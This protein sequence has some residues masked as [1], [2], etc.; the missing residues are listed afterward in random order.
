PKVLPK[1]ATTIAGQ[2]MAGFNCTRAN[3]TGSDP[4]G[5]SVADTKATT[6][7]VLSPTFGNASTASR[8]SIHASIDCIMR[9]PRRSRM[10]RSEPLYFCLLFQHTPTP[11]HEDRPH[12]A[13][14]QPL[15]RADGGCDG[16]AFSTAV[17][18]AR[19]RLCGQ[20]DGDLAPR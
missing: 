19:R 3:T 7:T 1:V 11:V 12:R 2:N 10:H 15:C 20:R 5:S 8:D 18:A 4:S 17:Q 14:E 6:N 9:S 16:P 13:A